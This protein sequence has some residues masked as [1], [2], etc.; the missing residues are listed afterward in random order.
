MSSHCTT[1]SD[2]QDQK[3]FDPKAFSVKTGGRSITTW[4]RRG[5][6]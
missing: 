3:Y 6:R 2:K 5:G 4:T 1:Y